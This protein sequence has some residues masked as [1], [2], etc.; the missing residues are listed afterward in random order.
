MERHK[1]ADVAGGTETKKIR[2]VLGCW[3]IAVWDETVALGNQSLLKL[4]FRKFYVVLHDTDAKIERSVDVD[5]EEENGKAV[6][7]FFSTFDSDGVLIELA[8]VV[9]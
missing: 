6:L 1:N 4:I 9:G 7:P 2:M 5:T 3:D 8:V